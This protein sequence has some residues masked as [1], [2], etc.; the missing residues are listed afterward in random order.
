[1]AIQVVPCQFYVPF[2][3]LKGSPEESISVEWQGVS[4]RRTLQCA[5][6]HRVSLIRSFLGW[7]EVIGANIIIHRP[8]IYGI[9]SNLLTA[10]TA[11]TK[12]FG[13]MSQEPGDAR[14]ADY[15]YCRIEIG[16]KIL[17]S[18][19]AAAYGQVSITET[20]HDAGEFV[21][22]P[23]K[24]LYWGTGGGKEAIDEMDAPGKINR[25]L[26]WTIDIRGAVAVPAGVEGHPGK[27]NSVEEVS[28]SF[29]YKFPP[30]TL[31]CG[32]PTI[33]K[34][35]S[36]AATTYDVTLRFLAKNNGTYVAPRG[37]NFFPRISA[38]GATVSYERITDG[39]DNKDFYAS[40]DFSDIMPW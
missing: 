35:V 27:V 32:N 38:A 4:A 34:E 29:G 16:Y 37:W 12:P 2:E 20:L 31:L 25:L 17:E 9:I 8:H 3:E 36:F 39:T 28:S 1:M 26:E 7:T 11:A 30:G 5:T 24:G 19:L 23:T 33:V 18:T 21:T 13:Q 14:F 10:C 15:P 6:V 22:I 40:A